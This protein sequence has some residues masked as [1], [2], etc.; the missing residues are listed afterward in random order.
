MDYQAH[1]A[2]PAGKAGLIRVAAVGDVHIGLDMKGE[3]GPAFARLAQDA[4]VLLIA[5]DLTQHG[6]REEGRL[7]AEEVSELGLPAVAVLGNHDSHL[8]AQDLIRS[9]LE[10]A[11]VTVLEG[12][13]VV[14]EL[15]GH[16]VGI[17]R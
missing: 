3:V 6:S 11:G 5:G 8:D 12:E 15:A 10:R 4:D 2:G 16:R 13:G 9:E 14:L 7:F 1:G 17:A